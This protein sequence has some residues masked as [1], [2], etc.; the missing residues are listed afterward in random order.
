[1]LVASGCKIAANHFGVH[2]VLG[3][4]HGCDSDVDIRL[5]PF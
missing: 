1:M 4:M 5:E 3:K 2:G